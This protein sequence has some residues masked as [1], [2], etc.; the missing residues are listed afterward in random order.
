MKFSK[1]IAVCAAVLALSAVS[2]NADG[3][4]AAGEKVFKKCA[5]CHVV[6][7]DDKKG[8]SDRFKDVIGRTAGTAEVSNIPKLMVEA[9]DG[10]LVWND[11]T[12]SG[13]SG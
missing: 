5:A 10:G 13:L 8:R 1:T 2:A 7:S 3:D 11:E 4:A 6:D 9:G 12:L